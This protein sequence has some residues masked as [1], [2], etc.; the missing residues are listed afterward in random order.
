MLSSHSSA[1]TSSPLPMNTS[2]DT[3]ADVISGKAPPEAD[4]GRVTLI[5]KTS[6]IDGKMPIGV[7]GLVRHMVD[8]AQSVVDV[9]ELLEAALKSFAIIAQWYAEPSVCVQP[10]LAKPLYYIRTYFT[11][12]SGNPPFV[13]EAKAVGKDYI[14][15]VKESVK[16]AGLGVAFAADVVNLCD[17]ISKGRDT[18]IRSFMDEM[19]MIVQQALDE[20][21]T[22]NHKFRNIRKRLVQV[23]CGLR[24]PLELLIEVSGSL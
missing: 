17:Y 5:S 10:S 21:A 2:E 20:A 1:H 12:S 24:S 18:D 16:V 13:N 8:G 11:H 23:R 14:E 19:R 3:L 6:A 4:S 7:D 22:T 15:A 9:D